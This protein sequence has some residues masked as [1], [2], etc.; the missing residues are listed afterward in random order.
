MEKYEVN[1]ID[2]S[3]PT[4]AVTSGH[5]GLRRCATWENHERR[6]R[7]DP[8]Y[9]QRCRLVERET[10]DWLRRHG[11]GGL[12]TGLIRIPVVVHVIYNTAAQDIS[13][14]QIHSQIDVLN[15]DF[16]R[17]NADASSTPS[18]FAGVAADARIEFA[19]AVRDPSCAPTSGITRTATPATGWVFTDEGMKAT[20]TGGH[21][22]W[23]VTKYLNVWVVNYTDS[24]LGYGTFPS[25][26]A[27][28]QGVACHYRA[29]G[30]GSS[31]SLISGAHLGRT[32]T[33][34]VG[35]WLNLIHIW[36]G[37]SP[38]CT[39]SDSIGDTPNQNFSSLFSGT[40]C[41]TFPALSCSNGPNGDMFINYMDYSGDQC[42]NL[43]TADQVARMDAAL[44]TQ[45]QGILGSDALEPAPGSPGP[46]LWMKDT[47][48]DLGV[49]PD[50]SAQAM[51]ISDD[52][53][54][55]TGNDGLA[56]QDHQNPEYR[57]SGSSPNN[58]Y[59]RVRNRGCTGSASGTLRVY[60]AKASTALS[61]PLPWDGTVTSPVLMGGA[62]GSTSVTVA[63]GDYEI[64]SFPWMPPNPA[65]YA[66]FG[67][68]QGHFCLL[69]RI[70]T[71]AT[72]PF[73]M[74]SSE[75]SDLMA[76]VRR[77][78]NIVWKN[79][80]VV[81]EVPGMGRIGSV[82]VGNLTDEP[83]EATIDVQVPRAG[84]P[85][86]FDF[87]LAFIELPQALMKQLDPKCARGVRQFD[88]RTLQLVDLPAR[89]GTFKLS[90]RELHSLNLWIVERHHE[91][92]GARVFTLDVV[93]RRDRKIVG[94]QRF[95]VKSRPA[96]QGIEIDRPA[97]TFDGVSWVDKG[98]A[99]PGGCCC[100]SRT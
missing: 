49:E 15:R 37:L 61:W 4:H 91:P 74:T 84:T 63:A 54:V 89:I 81:D 77:N 96:P 6:A 79:I 9:R 12:R 11:N 45:R 78:N 28:I 56:N 3:D 25:M 44:H 23:D 95:V 18:V 67:A 46:D 30:T 1:S 58:V 41:L 43:F 92:I 2:T 60:W 52:I 13:D 82:I 68:D 69:A 39:D 20:S 83:D 35:H 31:F 19:L 10:Q 75:T 29:F 71:S 86:I 7:R 76:N 16:R 34:E 62:I 51:W 73:G 22:P 26:P 97:S 65:D 66:S 42:M 14:A 55:R 93:R 21:D 53:W 57:P 33:H 27:N 70:E 85:S 38:S 100:P 36:G 80:A 98:E 5:R 8:G 17:L 87:G 59:V 90:P 32:M 88:E 72:A 40:T 48:D 99:E 50:P 94:G 47:S 24:T 64:Y